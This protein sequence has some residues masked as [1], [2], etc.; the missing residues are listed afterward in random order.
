MESS[1]TRSALL[2][3]R[4]ERQVMGE[5][6]RFLDE[7]RL[8]LA[9]EM[10]RQFEAYR[11]QRAIWLQLHQQAITALQQALSRHGLQGLQVQPA[12]VDQQLQ[13][14]QNLRRFFGVTLS[15]QVAVMPG[16]EEPPAIEP[17]GHSAEA[18]GCRHAFAR[19]LTASAELAALSGNVHRLLAEYKRT[20][21]RSRALENVLLPE[22]DETIREMDIRLEEMDQEEAVRVR[23]GHL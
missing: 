15:D 3:A 8:L 16:R 2:R 20:E 22:L 14:R 5:G 9:A 4:E 12:T 7:K 17:L 18:A 11:Q 13:I 1:P 21:R 23:L 6:F 19:L 10:A